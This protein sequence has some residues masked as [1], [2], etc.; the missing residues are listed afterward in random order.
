M[1]AHTA[2]QTSPSTS[3]N[4]YLGIDVG[5]NDLH[6][7]ATHKFLRQFNNT[8]AG[9]RTLIDK[10]KPMKPKLI[11]IEASGGYERDLVD[12]LHDADLPVAVVQP[13]C[14]R[15]FAKSGKV[16]AKT[17]A[18]DAQVI[19]RF[20]EAQQPRLT[21][22]TPQS[23]RKLR[24][25]R[26][27]RQQIVEDRVREQNRLETCADRAIAKHLRASIRRL[28]AQEKKFDQQ[29]AAH[30]KS[31]PQLNEKADTM[32]SLKGVG[33]QTVATLLAHMPELGQL[34]RQ[35]IA[36]LAGLAP[37]PRESG[38]WKGKR[39]IFAGRAAV[40]KVLYMAAKSAARFCPVI[41]VFYQRLRDQGKKYNVAIIACARKILVR[42]NTLLKQQHTT[43]NIAPGEVRLT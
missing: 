28:E 11:A 22:P 35:Q 37:H 21:E 33:E 18:I 43:N 17:D 10:V 3:P 31:D 38:K 9:H 1:K 40:R 29:I 30:I 13:A 15:H 34:D 19:A 23:V 4:A 5:K 14:V 41:S 7:G 39:R 12:A 24:A 27:R 16:L 36:A 26:D 20:A 42:L 32:T 6:L 2:Y 8:A 25:L